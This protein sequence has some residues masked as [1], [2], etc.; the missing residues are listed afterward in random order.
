VPGHE[1]VIEVVEVGE[2]V[3]SVEA[4]KRY[5]V[6][7]DWRELK[8]AG[9]NGAF[10]Y[11]F[12]GGLQQY[13]L[14]DERTTVASD[15]TSYLLPADEERSVS[16]TALVEPWACVEQAFIHSE[17]TELT[18]GGTVLY[19]R[20]DGIEG[21]PD[22][23]LSGAGRYLCLDNGGCSGAPDGATCV[24]LDAIE[25]GSVDDL[26]FYGADADLFEAVKGKVAKNGLIAICT[27][28]A[29]F[30][31]PV[32]VPVGRVHYGNV[33]L[34]GYPGDS[35]AKCLSR[36]PATGEIREDDRVHVVGAAG[37]MGSMATIRVISSG[38]GGIAVEA[39]D[40]AVD[41]LEV[42]RS[43]SESLAT[44][45]SVPLHLY[46]PKDE[47]A[48][49]APDYV[50]VMVPVGPL[51]SAAVDQANPGGVINI[52][53]GIPAEVEQALD[54]DAYCNKGL[55]FIG[56]SGSTMEDMEAVLSKVNAGDLDTN[57]SVGAVSGMGGA[58]PGLEAVRDGKV[59][60]KILV[61]PELGDFPMTSLEDLISQFP[62]IAPLLEEG[63]WTKAAEEELLRV[64]VP[65]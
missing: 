56:T 17:R 44:R 54:L 31:R 27:T 25:D 19:V 13:V 8:T 50:M 63:N 60:G 26:L 53:A 51:V 64:A 43:K 42:L 57:L 36:I 40:M 10:G 4:G 14:L 35:L 39:S 28:G 46:N 29:S 11:N 21:S 58:I 45:K 38:I 22:V 30:G 47:Q 5:L 6:Q 24:T 32:T 23:D 15:G 52:F 62:S 7:A 48:E 16:A 20:C 2:G 34:I 9:S 55:Y 61:Y 37:P 33:R 18:P 12:E 3:F 41:R 65:A 59:A 49:A 1:V